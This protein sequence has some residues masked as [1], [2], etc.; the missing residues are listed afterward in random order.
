MRPRLRPGGAQQ[1]RH[2][3]E[4]GDGRPEMPR[5]LRDFVVTEVHELPPEE[6]DD[7]MAGCTLIQLHESRGQGRQSPFIASAKIMIRGAT[8]TSGETTEVGGPRRVSL[9]RLQHSID[10]MCESTLPCTLFGRNSTTGSSLACGGF[11]T[12]R[13]IDL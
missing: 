4:Y 7:T 3:G 9:K 11:P 2:E 12:D 13:E 5:E 1:E 10:R 6:I 8:D